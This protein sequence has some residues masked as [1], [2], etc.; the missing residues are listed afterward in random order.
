[1][2]AKPAL[3]QDLCAQYLLCGLHDDKTAETSYTHN[4]PDAQA[5]RGSLMIS[6][7]T[8]ELRRAWWPMR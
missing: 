8:N 3:P 1:M 4:Y 5:L 6:D 7:R 2:Y